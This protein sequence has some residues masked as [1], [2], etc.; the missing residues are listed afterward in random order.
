MPDQ[1]TDEQAEEMLRTLAEHFHQPV[2]PIRRYCE[3][4]ETWARCIGE[5][6]E[7]LRTELFPN[8]N[9]WEETRDEKGHLHWTAAAEEQHAEYEA[10]LAK[11]KFRALI[12]V[13]LSSLSKEAT[14]EV[15]GLMR[16]EP[17]SRE[18]R[19]YD[20]IAYQE[21][22]HQVERTLLAVHKSNLLARLLYSGEKLRTKM[23]PI[24][25]GKWSG[26][27]WPGEACP[28]KCQLTGWIQEEEDQGKRLP[29]VQV[30]YTSGEAGADVRNVDGEIIGKVVV[31]TIKPV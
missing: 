29:G 1:L 20:L 24:H 23:C 6:A 10:V 13:G 26:V 25:K 16:K 15:L 14:R 4:L 17:T 21:A 5:R 27:E 19:I 11:D 28:H 7:R 22:A 30:V 2:Q 31:P 18:S 3:G 8:F 12:P 9:D